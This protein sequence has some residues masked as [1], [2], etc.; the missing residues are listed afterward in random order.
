[1][2][3]F[4]K[5]QICLSAKLTWNCCKAGTVC[6]DRHEKQIPY[7]HERNIQSFLAK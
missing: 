4:I 1:M 5:E 7:E 6:L 2:E 3:V